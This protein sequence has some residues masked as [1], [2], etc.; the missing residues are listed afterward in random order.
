MMRSKSKNLE[1]DNSTLTMADIV[2]SPRNL[3][4]AACF[5]IMLV[6]FKISLTSMIRIN[7]VTFR[8]FEFHCR[9]VEMLHRTKVLL[10]LKG[11]R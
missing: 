7:S 5:Y 10:N 6:L 9:A 11:A 1:R 8:D 4:V 2:L 3:C